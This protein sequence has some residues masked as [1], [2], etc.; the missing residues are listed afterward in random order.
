M[1]QVALLRGINV[2][3]NNIIPMKQLVELCQKKLGWE[4][5]QTYIQSGNVVFTSDEARPAEVLRAAIAKR[6]KLDIPVVTRTAKALDTVVKGNPFPGADP[7]LL[8]V[9]FL[10][11]TPTATQV[12]RLDP[13]RSPGD[14]FRVVGSHL[15][16]NYA[17]GVAKTK[18]TPQ[19]LDSRLETM[20]TAR[21]WRTVLT[22]QELLG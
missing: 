14:E 15:Y 20:C 12:A 13:E 22:L 10:S 6:F 2:G 11:T 3:G 4:D 9:G 19:Y 17:G 7:K 18:L 5:V 8:H 21:N 16:V 1:R